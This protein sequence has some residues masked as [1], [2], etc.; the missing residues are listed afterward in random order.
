[1]NQDEIQKLAARFVEGKATPEEEDKLHQWYDARYSDSNDS[2]H[3]RTASSREELKR[4]IRSGVSPE[5][6]QQKGRGNRTLKVPFKIA[7]AIALMAITGLGLYLFSLSRTPEW[8]TISV[9]LGETVEILLPDS[10]KVWINAGSIFRYPKKF[11]AQG[12]RVELINGQAFFEVR[13]NSDNPFSVHSATFDVTVLGTSFDIKSYDDEGS[14]SIEVRSGQVKVMVPGLAE[15][16]ILTQGKMALIS[17]EAGT[18]EVREKEADYIGAWKEGRVVFYNEPM[19]MVIN[20]LER[21]YNVR[22]LADNPEMLQAP[23]TIKL[24]RQPLRDIL[25]ALKYI[26]DF[27]YNIDEYEK[28]ITITT[29]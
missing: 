28:N 29:N 22:I 1:M 13:K 25:E 14:A 17:K 18:V 23:L 16:E 27:Q 24:D 9:P 6:H 21:N 15:S 7:A 4:R 20:A 3:V 2:L 11:G 19:T 5:K 10:S 12:R 26:F 8:V